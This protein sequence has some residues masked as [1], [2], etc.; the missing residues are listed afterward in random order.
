MAVL[1]RRL[2]AEAEEEAAPGSTFPPAP[3]GGRRRLGRGDAEAFRSAF[4][5]NLQDH[6]NA[7]SSPPPHLRPDPSCQ[8]G[9][10]LYREGPLLH[11]P[12]ELEK[13]VGRSVDPI[14]GAP[15][16]TPLRR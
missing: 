4:H 3:A 5:V 1:L 13:R 14:P 9:R 8:L 11:R 7:T 10:E 16:N 12:L 6:S 15:G 2:I